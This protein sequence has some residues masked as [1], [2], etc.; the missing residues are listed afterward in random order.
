M[1]ILYFECEK[2]GEVWGVDEHPETCECGG[3]VKAYHEDT[4]KLIKI[5]NRAE[6][7]KNMSEKVNYLID[8]LPGSTNLES[9]YAKIA[10]TMIALEEFN[11]IS[12]AES[13]ALFDRARKIYNKRVGI[14]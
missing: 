5:E 14:K 4:S 3:E 13:D 6:W 8:Y 1:S 9:D 7:F 12:K 11:I 2:C 10:G